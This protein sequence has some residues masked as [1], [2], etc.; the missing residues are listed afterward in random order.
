[1]GSTGLWTS[2]CHQYSVFINPKN[3]HQV[4]VLCPD[5]LML[6]SAAFQF[7]NHSWN[8]EE[9]GKQTPKAA[10]II[11]IPQKGAYS[12]HCSPVKLKIGP[13]SPLLMRMAAIL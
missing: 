10:T 5:I 11:A 4:T 1:M 8:L 3:A 9:P 6:L 2:D 12:V 7:A 13:P